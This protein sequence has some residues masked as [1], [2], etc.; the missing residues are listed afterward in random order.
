MEQSDLTRGR[1]EIAKAVAS[2]DA[3]R[4]VKPVAKATLASSRSKR[5]LTSL[6]PTS[7]AD[8]VEYVVTDIIVP[9]IKDLVSD[10][11]T[12]AVENALFGSTGRRGGYSRRSTLGSGWTSRTD[13]SAISKPKGRVEIVSPRATD[14]HDLRYDSRATAESVLAGMDRHIQRYGRATV[15]DLMTLSG[16]SSSPIDEKWYWSDI[17]GANVRS[18]RGGYIITLPDPEDDK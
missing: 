1:D 4:E 13:Y 11:V 2:I 15:G 5:A 12:G 10:A 6:F 9:A 14:W 17:T 3:D 7:P 8:V 16:V 18:S